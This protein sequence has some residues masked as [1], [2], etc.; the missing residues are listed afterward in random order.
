M[1]RQSFAA[2]VT[3]VVLVDPATGFNPAA[4]TGW[5]TEWP[6][7]RCR[8]GVLPFVFGRQGCKDRSLARIARRSDTHGKGEALTVDYDTATFVRSRMPYEGQV[9]SFDP[10]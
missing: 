5:L 9:F 8:A 6:G 7:Q 2:V 4:R 10:K 1:T 3:S